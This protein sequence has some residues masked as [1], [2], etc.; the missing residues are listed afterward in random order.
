MKKIIL[1]LFISF[2]HRTYCK[3]QSS[4]V[5]LHIKTFSE[6]DGTFREKEDD[7]SGNVEYWNIFID[8]LYIFVEIDL[9]NF[10][11]NDLKNLIDEK[12]RQQ[13]NPFSLKLT[14]TD[15]TNNQRV[16]IK[17]FEKKVSYSNKIKNNFCLFQLNNLDKL[18]AG[19]VSFEIKAELQYERGI[20]KKGI[21]KS[22]IRSAKKTVGIGFGE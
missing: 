11:E 20:Y 8:E 21:V 22:I 5:K 3:A 18:I 19:Y 1:L 4:D 14:L 7:G 10:V 6:G 15:I 16:V 12:T 2:L 17:E 13:F 9:K